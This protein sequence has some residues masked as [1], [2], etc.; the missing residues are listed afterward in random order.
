MQD[1][2]WCVCLFLLCLVLVLHLSSS[3]F[4]PL[5][6]LPPPLPHLLL[7]LLL[8]SILLCNKATLELITTSC[9]GFLS[10]KIT[11]VHYHITKN[12]P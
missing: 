2:F 9:L 12:I 6:P 8:D 10:I 3:P 4:S 1:H 11:N 7:F 5:P